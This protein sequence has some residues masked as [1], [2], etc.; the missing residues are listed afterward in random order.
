[1]PN[2]KEPRLEESSFS[3]AKVTE[4]T[5]E[6]NSESSFKSEPSLAAEQDSQPIY[7]KPH[8]KPYQENKQPEPEHQEYASASHAPFAESLEEDGAEPVLAATSSSNKLALLGCVLAVIAV[9]AAGGLWY[10]NKQT[11]AKYNQA[12]DSLVARLQEVEI[13]L[14]ETGDDLSE[15]GNTFASKL[16]WADSEIRKLWVV[17]HQRNL[18]NIEKLQQEA[19][20]LASQIAANQKDISA[21]LQAQQKIVQQLEQRLTELSLS[22]STFSQRLQDQDTRAEVKKLQD[23]LKKVTQDLAQLAAKPAAEDLSRT[24]A[25]HTEILQSLEASR[26]QLTQRVTRLMEDVNQLQ[27]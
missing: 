14:A 9:F 23:Q 1:M 21:N 18:P 12:I 17:A 24:V 27:Q 4:A 20:T 8:Q 3:P 15:A 10:A 13:R 11:A 26:A 7:L 5:P 2:R 19:K 16:Q 25:E 6:I 22:S